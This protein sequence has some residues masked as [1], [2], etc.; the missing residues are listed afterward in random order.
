[1]GALWGWEGG[2]EGLGFEDEDRLR[3]FES[4]DCSEWGVLGK[5]WLLLTVII[6]SGSTVFSITSLGG[7][8]SFVCL[9]MVV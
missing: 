1:M 8:G 9:G 2:R 3:E 4:E 7:F 5:V 6:S